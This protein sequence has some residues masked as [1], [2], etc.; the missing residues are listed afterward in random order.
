MQ[1]ALKFLVIF[2]GILILAGLAVIAIE[3]GSRFSG[4]GGD[5]GKGGFGTVELGLPAGTSVTAVDGTVDRLFVTTRLPDG[6]EQILILDL[7][8]GAV[9]GRVNVTAAP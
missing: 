7:E 4:R 6:R 8:S 1:Q 3:L 9:V 5:A 2:M